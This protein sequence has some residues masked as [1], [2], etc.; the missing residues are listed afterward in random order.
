MPPSL[1]SKVD[2]NIKSDVKKKSDPSTVQTLVNI[3][4]PT[5]AY[6]SSTS[7][8]SPNK[9]SSPSTTLK[10]YIPNKKA[11]GPTTQKSPTLTTTK[12]IFTQSK[13]HTSDPNV[14]NL[15]YSMQPTNVDYNSN[16]NEFLFGSSSSYMEPQYGPYDSASYVRFP[17]DQQTQYK[18]PNSKF[19]LDFANTF[20][21]DA[22]SD[23]HQQASN[24]F[25]R[26]PTISRT[27][28]STFNSNQQWQNTR[29][30]PHQ[31]VQA[32]ST[33]NS[34]WPPHQQQPQQQY[35]SQNSRYQHNVPLTNYKLLQL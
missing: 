35:Y 22:T 16:S 26:F 3:V 4:Q 33:W 29:W 20:G 24:S 10:P 30:P 7:V 15:M 23:T 18:H 25:I 8:Y 9:K 32:D 31:T 14:Y 34:R 19:S 2:P 6:H 17:S 27:P 13:P 28:A 11:A 12:R 5:S 21:G 1:P